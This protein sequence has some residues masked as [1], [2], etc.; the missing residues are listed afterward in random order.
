MQHL[1][2]TGTDAFTATDYRSFIKR[3]VT[4][5]EYTV[6]LL[7]F[8]MYSGARV[9]SPLEFLRVSLSLSFESLYFANY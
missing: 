6:T 3:P 4:Q 2:A 9:L 5:P 1:L 7:L 8:I